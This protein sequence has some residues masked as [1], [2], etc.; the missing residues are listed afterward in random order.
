MRSKIQSLARGKAGEIYLQVIADIADGDGLS[1]SGFVSRLWEDYIAKYGH[2]RNPNLNG[3]FFELAIAEVLARE[4]IT[5]FY[6]QAAFR[7]VPNAIFD[8]ICYR[9]KTPVALSAKSS[10]R[11]RYKQADLEGM[12]LKQ[13][14]RNSICYLLTMSHDEARRVNRKIDDGECVGIDKCVIADEQEFDGLIAELAKQQFSQAESEPPLSS[15]EMI[16]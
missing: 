4:K 11:E 10:L 8:F 7:L 16:A 2:N 9:P 3:R 12:A 6:V 13:V 5:P 1:P 15:G 14:Y